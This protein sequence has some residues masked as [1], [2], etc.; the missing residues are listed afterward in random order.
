[1]AGLHF[2]TDL[3]ASL[4]FW[5][6]YVLTRPLGATLGD[7]LTKPQAEGGLGLGRI[8]SSLAIAVAMV[9]LVALTS[10]RKSVPAVASS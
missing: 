6:A 5:A 1:V 9:I 3:P 7:T 4:V 10:R 2:F 8:T